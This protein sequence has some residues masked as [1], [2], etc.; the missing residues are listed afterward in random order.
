MPSGNPTK[1]IESRLHNSEGTHATEGTQQRELKVEPITDVM[2]GLYDSVNP[3][4]GIERCN[5]FLE[6]FPLNPLEPNK[7]N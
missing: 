6:H 1:G 3:T 4:K 5:H 7:G 2:S